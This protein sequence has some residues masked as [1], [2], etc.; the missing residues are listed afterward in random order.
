MILSIKKG[1]IDFNFS[2]Y[3]DDNNFFIRYP[4]MIL[5]LITG[6]KWR[7]VKVDSSYRIA[8]DEFAIECW[9]KDDGK[10][11]HF[12]RTKK[13]FNSL[14]NSQSVKKGKII[15]YRICKEI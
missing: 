13:G 15:S 6:K 4:A 11:C 9:S 2:N 12:C 8:P 10:S 3:S 14:E 1:F 5:E 7:V